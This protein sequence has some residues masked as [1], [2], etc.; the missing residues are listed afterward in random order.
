VAP[1]V[2]ADDARRRSDEAVRRLREESGRRIDRQYRWRAFSSWCALATLG[3]GIS[4]AALDAHEAR[5][6]QQEQAAFRT[7]A[8]RDARIANACAGRTARFSAIEKEMGERLR[9]AMS[10]TE[11][12]HI[13]AHAEARRAAATNAAADLGCGRHVVTPS[14]WQFEWPGLKVSPH[15]PRGEPWADDPVVPP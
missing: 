11:Q 6:H 4:L 7:A 5:L 2:S 3:A 12:A 1:E 14:L 9:G 10:G 15:L 8:E 13:R